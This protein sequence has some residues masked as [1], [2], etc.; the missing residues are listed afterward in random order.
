MNGEQLYIKIDTAQIGMASAIGLPYDS[1]MAGATGKWH[2][3]AQGEGGECGL[4]YS[5][6]A[7]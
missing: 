5:G 4:W 2:Y 7:T 3:E 1:L 6:S